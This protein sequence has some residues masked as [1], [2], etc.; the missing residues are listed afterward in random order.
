MPQEN[1]QLEARSAFIDD[2]IC[3]LRENVQRRKAEWVFNLEEVA[4]SEWEDPQDKKAIFATTIDNQAGRHCASRGLKHT[5]IIMYIGAGGESLTPDTVMSHDCAP[6]RKRLMSRD[7]RMGVNSVLRQPLK[8]YINSRL[9]F[10]YINRIFASYHVEPQETE[11][12]E[13]CEAVLLTDNCPCHMSDDV[14]VI[15]TRG[16]VWKSLRECSQ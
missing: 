15:L 13:A 2:T 11:E 8:L 4:I 16:R 12:F 10:E 6:F 7:V 9:F 14:I 3:D 5:S 1:T